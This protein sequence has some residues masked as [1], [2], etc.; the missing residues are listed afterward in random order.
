M[1]VCT[2]RNRLMINAICETMRIRILRMSTRTT[3]QPY[4]VLYFIEKE[5][6]RDKKTGQ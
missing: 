5:R 4:I 3:D 1:K 2:Y 6:E